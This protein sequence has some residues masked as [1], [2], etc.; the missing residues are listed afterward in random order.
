MKKY[1][2]KLE[3]LLSQKNNNSDDSDET[4]MKIWFDSGDNLLFKKP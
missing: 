2:I 4:C 1:G 3:M